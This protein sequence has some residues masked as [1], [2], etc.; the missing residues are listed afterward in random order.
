[1]RVEVNLQKLTPWLEKKNV[2]AFNI[3]FAFPPSKSKE[4]IMIR[5]DK[6]RFFTLSEVEKE[7]GKPIFIILD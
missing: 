7:L 6:T 4:K 1:M 3:C 5:L 2:A